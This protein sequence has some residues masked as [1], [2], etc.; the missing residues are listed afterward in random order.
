MCYAACGMYG[1]VYS[2]MLMI[3]HAEGNQTAVATHDE[4]YEEC[5]FSSTVG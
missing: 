5:I 2:G 3:R 1:G 4:H